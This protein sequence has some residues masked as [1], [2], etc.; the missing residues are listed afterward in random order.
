MTHYP[1]DS[2][3]AIHEFKMHGEYQVLKRLESLQMK[4]IFDV[5]CNIGEWARMARSIHKDAFIHMFELVP[6]TFHK[7]VNN[8]VLDAKMYPNSFGLSDKLQEVPIQ[9]VLDN[10]R[11]STVVMDIHHTSSVLKTG[12]VCSAESYIK[13]HGV[14]YIDFLKLDTE[15]HEFNVLQGFIP[16][17]QTGSIGCIQFEYGYIAILTKNLLIDFY[18]FLA[19]FGYV[20][21]KLTPDGVKFK[22]YHLL[23]EDFIGPDYIAVHQSRPDMIELIKKGE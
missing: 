1:Y 8:N 11:V 5:G 9:V 16:L 4:M 19:P 12:L 20:I 6:E 14:N 15:G 3:I 2:K 22:D 10:D 7:M 23:D 21:G 17:L 13:Y 18:K